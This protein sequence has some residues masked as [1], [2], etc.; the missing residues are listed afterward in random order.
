MATQIIYQSD[1]S[2][3]K[4]KSQLYSLLYISTFFSLPFGLSV[5]DK[6]KVSSEQTPDLHPTVLPSDPQP[7]LKKMILWQLVLVQ[8]PR[9][10]FRSS[11]LLGSEPWSVNRGRWVNRRL[12]PAQD[13]V[14]CHS[15]KP[16]RQHALE[17]KRPGSAKE[18]CKVSLSIRWG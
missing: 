9:I 6:V 4:K 18:L 1:F 3:K 5:T 7:P 14:C 13:S 2:F 11:S 12:A 15:L 10:S 17:I 16:K 8:N